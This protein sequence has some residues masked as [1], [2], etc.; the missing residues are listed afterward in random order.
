M[1]PTELAV[2]IWGSAENYT[3]SAG[4]RR[5]RAVA[6]E[7]FPSDAPGQGGRWELSSVQA[8]AIRVRLTAR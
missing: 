1:T 4:A 5:V 8:D 6:R 2:E 3:R 7:L